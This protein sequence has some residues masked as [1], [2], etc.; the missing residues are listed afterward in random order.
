MSQPITSRCFP[1]ESNPEFVV[2]SCDRNGPN[3]EQVY[4]GG[5]EGTANRAFIDEVKRLEKLRDA[6]E[7]GLTRIKLFENETLIEELTI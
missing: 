7:I 2:L 1:P 5:D 3:S 6:G 4:F